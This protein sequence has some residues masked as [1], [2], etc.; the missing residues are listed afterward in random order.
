MLYSD[1][2]RAIFM[3]VQS[4]ENQAVMI[5]V[6]NINLPKGVSDCKFD[7][8]SG[9]FTYIIDRKIA[10]GKTSTD[11][12]VRLKPRIMSALYK[13]YGNPDI[14]DGSY[15]V[16]KT[17]FRNIGT[18]DIT[19]LKISYRLG[20]YASWSP[21]N[22]Y[23]LVVPGGTVVDFYYP[24]ISPKIAEL[25]SETPCD[26][27]VKYSYKD[28]SGK[29]YSDTIS[30]RLQILGINQFEFSNLPEEERTG[31][32][33]D[34]FSNSPLVA[35]FVTKLDDAVKAFAGMVS[36]YSG[37]VAAA[38]ND[39]DALTFCKA[40]YDLEVINGI[41]YQTS[42]G[43]LVEYFSGGQDLKY[44]RDVL[45]DKA[46]TC[47]D[48]AILYASV[49]EAVGLKTLIILIPGHAFP[50]VKAG[51]KNIKEL[52]MGRYFVINVEEPQ[53]R[54]I[55]T[56]ELPKLPADILRQW[57]YKGVGE[58]AIQPTPQPVPQP[59][60]QPG[61]NISGIY[62]G[63]YKNNNTGAV[64]NMN[65][66]I[67]QTGNNIQGEIEIVNEGKGTISGNIAG[68]NIQFTA[69]LTT[70]YGTFNVTFT[71]TVQGNTISGNYTIPDAGAN[72]TFVINR[73]R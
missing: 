25:K 48:L 44:P 68:T 18:S 59:T 12:T 46:G 72:G 19:D 53:K 62:Q 2:K 71:G 45:R 30:Y 33:A 69:N 52:K 1:N 4:L 15:W 50:V 37:G 73:I 7:S 5:Q 58:V 24:I 11:V 64:G 41:S 31:A 32:W 47:I 70:Y 40:L 8:K 61:G 42:S 54:G 43:F 57:G 26:L 39:E 14:F 51:Q 63:T 36:Q 60:P 17:I 35:A 16:A 67:I 56:P 28:S 3:L 6:L 22:S 65:V 21:E 49:C 23:S 20:D 55:S 38:S 27:V 29:S 66:S 13:V 34:N 9:L 10:K